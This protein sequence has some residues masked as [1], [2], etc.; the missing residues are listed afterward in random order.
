MSRILAA[1]LAVPLI[2]APLAPAAAGPP[3]K[4]GKPDVKVV[5]V[6]RQGE[7]YCFERAIVFG[8]IVIAG[9]RC[10]TFYL[11]RTAAGGFLGFGP[12]GPPMIPPGQIVRMN[13]PAG[14]KMKGRLFY[15]VP[16]SVP[17]THIP[18]DT[19]RFVVV[20]VDP[21]PERVVITVPPSSGSEPRLPE[22]SFGQR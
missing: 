3:A 12:P 7:A 2:L 19:I 20:N 15:L 4:P 6:T 5:K 14:A 21:K 13:T 16:F 8:N 22:L 18:V 17:V 11:V 1:A 9:G 10:Y